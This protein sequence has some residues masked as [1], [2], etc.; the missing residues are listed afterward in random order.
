MKKIASI[1]KLL[2]VVSLLIGGIGSD[3]VLADSYETD[4][5]NVVGAN[6]SNQIEL[7]TIGAD[8][9]NVAA[10]N[11]ARTVSSYKTSEKA[12]SVDV[13][14]AAGS[15]YAVLGF[16]AS[17]KK[18]VDSGWQTGKTYTL[19]K[20]VASYRLLFSYSDNRSLSSADTLK[21]ENCLT[22]STVQNSS[23]VI[24]VGTVGADGKNV[25]ATNRARTVSS[26][27][28][29][30]KAFS[31]DV[32]KAAGSR[33]AVLGFD[34]SG[35]KIVDSGWQTGKTYTLGKDVASYRLL[36]SYSDNRSLSS[37][38]TLK[39][40]NC[41]TLS[42]VQNSSSVIEVGTVGADGKNVAAT[43]RARTVSSYKTS[44]KAFSVDVSKAA[45]SRY[46]VLGFDASGKK[47][48]DSGW[49]TG[50][51]YTLGKDVASY[52]LLFSYS[53][54][55]SLS[56][57][58]T[59]KFENCLTLSTVQ[60]S[61]SV[62][63]VGTVGADG[64]NV[65][66]TNRARTV[67]SYKTSEKAFS[68]DVSKAA[69]SR[70]AVLG[71]DASGKKIVDSGWQTGKTYTLGKDVASYRLLFSYSDNR[72]LSSADT[73]KFE[74][75]LTLSTVQNSS[76]VIEVGTV[77]ADGKNVAATNRA[78]TVS[79]YKTSEKAFSV[80]VSKAAGSRYAVLGFDASGKKIVD[81]GWQT[82]KTYT[83]GKD[84]ASYRLLFSYSDNRS[85]SSADTLKFENCLT[86]STVQNSSSVIE[87]GTVGADGKNVAATN[88]ARTVS[89]Y[90]TSEKAFSVDVSKAAGSRYAVLG[91][92]ASGKKIVD[93][94][95]QTGKTYTLGKDVASYRLLF[96]YSDN[97]SLS[98]A[99]TLKFE[100]CLTLS[101]V[102]NSSSVIEVGTVGADGKN[103]AATNRARTVSSYKTSEKAFSV[104]VSKAAG[105]R[106]AVLGFDASG[107]KIVDS[108][109]QTG[110]TYTLG[111]DV[112]SYRLLFS[113]S[114]NRSLSSADTLVFEKCLSII[115]ASARD[116]WELPIM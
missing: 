114:D 20:D 23:S 115:P 27:K 11:R 82:G 2:L 64:K 101:T 111:K 10:T 1:L 54:N 22:L 56:S 88:R 60:N 105:S 97:R 39:F 109:W 6:A 49:Q 99:D 47:I 90:K 116:D 18:I 107:K 110:K 25:A 96:S 58:D 45:G 77:G 30:E 106:Y 24:E 50:K 7:G 76:S 44:E 4:S 31:V 17:G 12:F 86:L 40:E 72:S 36:F 63:E 13:S 5:I 19:G 46:A 16:D 102:Q 75:C 78:R 26:Y 8:G 34:A 95:W 79:S 15:R 73:L 51:T 48:V 91:F 57:A 89:S 65:A 71:F 32:S 9:K 67:S 68:V 61:S 53:D 35:K 94:G 42:T 59:L 84:V 55:R 103:V 37:A 113:Y 21:F 69:G 87:V 28:T 108:G 62:I 74:N 85:L 93:S 70:Y 80:D 41:L 3:V 112:A 29:S 66:A 104:D 81:S 92:D 98:S 14:K 52:R 100:N 38:D 83:L 33:Y 43:N